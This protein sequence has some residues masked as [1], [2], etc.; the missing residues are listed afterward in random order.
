MEY[1]E[2]RFPEMKEN[3]F[4]HVWL[5]P[6]SRGSAGT[7]DMGYGVRDYY[8][9]GEYGTA[10]W[11]TRDRL[12]QAMLTLQLND[13]VPVADMVYNHRDGGQW[14]DNPAVKGW[15]ENFNSAK[16]AQGDRPYPSDR[17]KIR[18]PLGGTS[19]N[20][21]G[22]Y[23]IK[24]RSASQHPNYYGKAYEFKVQTSTT[25]VTNATPIAEAEPN[26]GGDC[27]EGF[28][29]VPLARLVH[30]NVDNGGCGIDEYAVTITAD[31]FDADGDYIVMTLL[32]LGESGL[33]DMSDQY[34]HGIWYA[35]GGV[36]LKSQV[37]YQTRTDFTT[38]SSGLGEMDYT[39]FKPNGNPT[40]LNG[41]YDTPYYFY[42]LD[43]TVPSTR[44]TLFDWTTWMW[45]D[46]GIRGMRL[47]AVKHFDPGFVGD[48]LD[49]LHDQG[50]MPDMVVGELFDYNPSVLKGWTDA[51][52]GSMDNDAAADITPRVFDFALRE[53]LRKSVDVFGYDVR[54]LFNAGV[55]N[56]AGGSG[57]N[58]VT[59]AN[60][61]DFQHQ[62]PTIDNDIMLPY[63]YILT[64]NQLG[65]PCVFWSDYYGTPENFNPIN[66]LMKAHRLYITGATEAHYLSA[67][68]TG[69][70]SSYQS[71]APNTSLIYQLSNAESG[72]E[73]I[74][75][76][77]FSGETMRVDHQINTA[78]IPVG[79][80]L[81]DLL[82][83]SANPFAIVT[84]DSRAYFELPARSFGVWVQ[85]NLRDQTLPLDSVNQ[86]VTSVLPTGG[87]VEDF[88]FYPNPTTG[89]TTLLITLAEA[90]EGQWQLYDL[91]GRQ[92]WQQA[93]QLTAG[94]TTLTTDWS[95]L[96][97]GMYLLSWQ[98]ERGRVVRKMVLE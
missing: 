52:Y 6:L 62:G 96:P 85:G 2:A 10:R 89:H 48:L 97:S 27:G 58:T 22:T 39:N 45:N 3:G 90:Q 42:D 44:Q 64:N 15:V 51:V 16:V 18:V 59:F 84:S 19:G 80:T 33:A 66:N 67:F 17:V 40:N 26:G 57:F 98:S 60:N 76:I 13:M 28:Q 82:E 95:H 78:N 41:E 86:I 71:G 4:T 24:V 20:G 25:P 65:T 31:D 63:A 14:E 8:D 91:Q 74:V 34:I 77:N 21:A 88:T 38:L 5:P 79:D 92:L 1:I 61:H 37:A 70:G 81:T 68:N 49:H 36:E 56:G 11:G 29:T 47:D 83:T 12:D 54:N 32:N 94:S 35:E 87:V 9:L 72:R 50:M 69:Y 73:V 30:A 43:H 53:E 23:Y 93:A 75:A 46:A 55:V 7:A